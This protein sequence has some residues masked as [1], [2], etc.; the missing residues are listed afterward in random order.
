MLNEQIW[1]IFRLLQSYH[2]TGFVSLHL[3][4]V[5]LFLFIFIIYIFSDI[6]EDVCSLKYNVGADHYPAGLPV[7]HPSV[8]YPGKQVDHQPGG[9]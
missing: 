2:N 7:Q 9:R 4:F 1:L 3:Y 5:F 6:V 8:L